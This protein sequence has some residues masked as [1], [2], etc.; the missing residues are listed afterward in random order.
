MRRTLVLIAVLLVGCSTPLRPPAF[1]GTTPVL[2]PIQWFAGRTVSFGVFEDGSGAP[3][4]HFETDSDGKIE[5]DGSL[6]LAQTVR[7]HGDGA[8]ASVYQRT[9][10]MHRVDAH[11]YEATAEPVEGVAVGEAYGRAFHWSYTIRLPP[12]GWLHTVAFEHWMYL[13]DD[14]NTLVNRFVVRKLGI[15]VARATETFV[16][17]HP[18]P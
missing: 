16:H 10:H 12:G 1:E 11:R 15:I 17:T 2:D 13:S 14:G 4:S 6:T 8:D 3:T 5:P 9:W 7:L 18:G